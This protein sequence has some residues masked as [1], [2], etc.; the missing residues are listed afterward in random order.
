MK[1]GGPYVLKVQGKNAV[2]RSDVLVGEVWL[3]SGQSNMAMT[4]GGV[5]HK[6]AEIAAADHP[7]IRMF[8]VDRKTAEEP[9]DDCKGQW[10]VCSPKTVG[11]FLGGRLFLRRLAQATESAGRTHQFL[12]GRHADPRLDQRQGARGRAQLA[13]M[14]ESLKRSIARMTPRRPRR[15]MK[16]SWPSGRRP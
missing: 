15:V 11:R 1:A 14:L 6:D 12:V 16:R 8:T 10:Q 5:L 7:K 2:E 13:P 4:V 9:K 3:G